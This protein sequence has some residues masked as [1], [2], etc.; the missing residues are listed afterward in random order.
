LVHS[1]LA[2]QGAAAMRE[3]DS[4]IAFA[5][6]RGL[7]RIRLNRPAALN[8]LTLDMCEQLL[9]QLQAW[10]SAPEVKAVVIRGAGDRAFCAGGDVVGLYRH[11]QFGE[12]LLRPLFQTEY[13]CNAQI[14]HFPKPYI[15]LLDGIVMGG[16]AGISI[17]GSHRIA[18]ERTI[19]AMP[20]TA[21]GLFPD[22]GATYFLS[23]L[24]GAVGMYLGLTGRRLQGAD[25]VALGLAQVLVPRDRLNAL[26]AALEATDGSAA[27]VTDIIA[28]FTAPV[29]DAAIL[30]ERVAIDRHF[31]AD[32]IEGIMASL[33]SEQST[34]AAEQLAVLQKSSP[35]ALKV[36]FR[37]LRGGAALDFD[38]CIKLEW[39]MMSRMAR[40]HDFYEG[41]RARLVEKDNAPRWQYAQLAD[42]PQAA[43]D[44]VFAPLPDDELDL[45]DIVH[46]S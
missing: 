19:F 17:H 30:G 14:K 16:G 18:T 2:G 33:A 38:G 32:S 24:P 22:V 36:A 39:R 42:V 23:R 45:S 13:R 34:W 3:S 11:R 37:Q 6:D 8:T 25:C 7:A 26:D 41:V 31:S 5:H 21:I 40:G 1:N 44:A 28:S 27:N 12:T 35:F 10:R 46:G 43:V 20:E 9:A 15:A 29:G 4:D